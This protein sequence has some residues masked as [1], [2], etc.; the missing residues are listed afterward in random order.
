MGNAMTNLWND[1][2]CGPT[3]ILALLVA[4][5]GCAAPGRLMRGY[6]EAEPTEMALL[7]TGG[8]FAD[9]PAHLQGQVRFAFDAFGSLST[10]ALKRSAIPWK[11]AVAAVALDRHEMSGAPLSRGT[12][13]AVFEEYGLLRPRRIANW[14]GPQPLMERPLGVVSG[15]AHRGF[16]SVELEIAAL[17]CA[18]CHAGPLYGAD[19]RPTGDAWLGLPNT[20]IDGSA[21]RN[22][23]SLALERQLPR[24]DALLEAVATIFPDVTD[25]ELSVLRKHVIPGA[26]EKLT[27]QIADES[28]APRFENG[29]PG[30][31]NAVATLRNSPPRLRQRTSNSRGS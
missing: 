12:A 1:P 25:D 26:L 29:G 14:E 31:M 11:L 22:T 21:L 20:S 15:M 23:L 17:G 7:E 8:A 5:P 19:G 6:A 16:P 2:I 4:A 27:T 18:T 13:Y 24:D 9:A 3:L 10:D 30:L 28:H